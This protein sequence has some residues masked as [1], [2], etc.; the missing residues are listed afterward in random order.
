[1]STFEFW[2]CLICAVLLMRRISACTISR[3][4]GVTR[5]V[6]FSRMRSAKQICSTASFTTPS[7]FSSLR[8]SMTCFASTTVRM[9]SRTMLFCT[10]SSAKKVC[11][12]GDGSASPVVSIITASSGF[13]F[14]CAFFTIFLRPAMRSPRTVQQMQPLFISMMF[15]S[16]TPV[17]TPP[18]SLMMRAS[19]MPTS[20]NSF[21]MMAIF[22]PWFTS[23][24]WF[25]RVVLPAPRKPVMM[26]VGVLVLS[27]PGAAALA[28]FAARST[29]AFS[30]ASS[31]GARICAAARSISARCAAPRPLRSSARRANI[32]AISFF[33]GSP[34]FATTFCKKASGVRRMS[35]FS[36]GGRSG[37]LFTSC[38]SQASNIP[39]TSWTPSKYF[40]AASAS[41]AARPSNS[42]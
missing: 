28:C 40:C 4:S 19:S 31:P 27:A 13:P 5:S 29:F 32:S 30:S 20:P 10:K 42:S 25:S 36:P 22:L 12:T 17:L 37:W 2:V 39:L 7:G 26:V 18:P 41:R 14:F 6:L 24:M 21:S 23:R 38:S 1:M 8:C 3:Y 11:A 15:S 9:P 35:I 34:I 16:V 33:C